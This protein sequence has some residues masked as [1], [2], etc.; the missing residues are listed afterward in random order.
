MWQINENNCFRTSY[1]HLL[2]ICVLF[3]WKKKK[4]PPKRVIRIVFTEFDTK[5]IC[6]FLNS[7]QFS[8]ST[9]TNQVPLILL[10]SGTTWDYFRGQAEVLGGHSCFQ[11]TSCNLQFAIIQA[12][13]FVKWLTN[14]RKALTY[15]YWFDIQDAIQK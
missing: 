2:V 6:I 4:K 14:I 7:S 13:W 15:Y 1:Y 5:C 11:P 12:W 10:N 8:K 3:Q 9:N